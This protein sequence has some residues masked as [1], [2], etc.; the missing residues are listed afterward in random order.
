MTLDCN[1]QL[2]NAVDSQVTVTT[3]WKKN[4]TAL[5]SLSR[6]RLLDAIIL[7]NS[8]SYLSQV[9]F[10]PF[11]LGSDDGAYSCEVT[12]NAKDDDGYILSAVLSSDN[13]TLFAEGTYNDMCPSI[14]T[15]F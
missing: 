2:M 1:I 15:I 11:E 5:T 6:R 12:L 10:G 14:H 4:G 8:S 7:S 13:V 9:V 3:V